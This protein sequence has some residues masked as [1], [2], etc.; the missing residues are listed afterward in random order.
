MRVIPAPAAPVAAPV[1]APASS[2]PT[3][4]T[5]AVDDGLS[6]EGYEDLEAQLSMAPAV[7]F[8]GPTSTP[9]STTASSTPA[10]ARL[11]TD[12]STGPVPASAEGLHRGV[13]GPGVAGL[14]LA[15]NAYGASPALAADGD[16]GPRTERSLR[17]LQ[18]DL[19]LP[20]TGT[21]DAATIDAMGKRPPGDFAVQPTAVPTV[22]GS[23][24]ERLANAARDAAGRRDTI[25]R[26]AGGVGDA[27]EAIGVKLRVPSAYLYAEKLGDDPRFK[28][29]FIDRH[30]LK[31]LPPGAVV[32]WGKSGTHPHGH[33][34][35]TVGAGKEASDHVQ[36]IRGGS[37]GGQWGNGV[38]TDQNFRVFMPAEEP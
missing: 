11:P 23:S 31:E 7:S 24:A 4:A 3:A 18:H 2:V 27:L 22:A 8:A 28:E 34:A 37:Y 17:L 26:C 1:G 38:T 30:Q 33:V 9:S 16:F 10:G 5:A 14:Q 20:V 13:H 12:A 6:V 32:V 35:I 29:V 25:G 19:G 21:L 15:L 36:S